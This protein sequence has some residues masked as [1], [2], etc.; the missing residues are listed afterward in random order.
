MAAPRV[1]LQI[2]SGGSRRLDAA[3]PFFPPEAKGI[4]RWSPICDELNRYMFKVT[5]LRDGR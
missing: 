4:L 3:L 2:L 1:P 5:G